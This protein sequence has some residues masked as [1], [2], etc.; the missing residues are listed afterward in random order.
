MNISDVKELD[1]SYHR[2]QHGSS[3]GIGNR[4]RLRM[5][6]RNGPEEP[7]APA[8]AVGYTYI[9]RHIGGS[10]SSGVGGRDTEHN[11]KGGT[12]RGDR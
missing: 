9:H 12:D 6:I 3:A 4:S 11:E 10:I 1:P 2:I 5:S 7:R 8:R